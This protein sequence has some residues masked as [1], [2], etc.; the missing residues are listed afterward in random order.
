MATNNCMQVMCT[1]DTWASSRKKLADAFQSIG[2]FYLYVTWHIIVTL[3]MCISWFKTLS[4]IRDS[5][6]A[7]PEQSRAGLTIV[8]KNVKHQ[9]VHLILS[10][11]LASTDMKKHLTLNIRLG[12]MTYFSKW[13]H[14]L[15]VPF[16][17]SSTANSTG[18]SHRFRRYNIVWLARGVIFRI[19]INV[20]RAWRERKK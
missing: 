6:V 14:R 18:A 5:E 12:Y 17:E 8:Q 16:M 2:I 10:D 13:I 9:K 15:P 20:C 7:R 19:P 1:K 4:L 11:F 3:C